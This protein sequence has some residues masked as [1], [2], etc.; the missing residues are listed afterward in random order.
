MFLDIFERPVSLLR[1]LSRHIAAV[2]HC[3]GRTKRCHR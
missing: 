3:N 1:H 2:N